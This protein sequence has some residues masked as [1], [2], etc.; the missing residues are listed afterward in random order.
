MTGPISSLP[1]AR[2]VPQLDCDAVGN[3]IHDHVDFAVLQLEH[4]E[5]GIGADRPLDPVD[6][7]PLRVPVVR[8]PLEDEALLE[9]DVRHRVRPG[10]DGRE[11]ELLVAEVLDDVPWNT[12]ANGMASR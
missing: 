4:G 7:R 2:V 8:E 10:A 3:P 5:F 11:I 1:S 9:I 6:V 12:E